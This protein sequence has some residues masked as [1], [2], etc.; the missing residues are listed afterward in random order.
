MQSHVPIAE[1][2]GVGS[3]NVHSLYI[4]RNNVEHLCNSKL[5]IYYI[6]VEVC[7]SRILL[8][9]CTSKCNVQCRVELLVV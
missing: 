9:C 2:G 5:L 6:Y 4:V 8:Q 1:M 7:T 3:D